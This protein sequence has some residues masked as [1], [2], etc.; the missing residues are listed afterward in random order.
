VAARYG[1][2]EFTV[3]LPQTT[4]QDATIIAER[5]CQEIEN[6]NFRPETSQ[7]S[8]TKLTVSVGLAS[9]PEDA[10]QLDDLIK[11]ADTALYA[12]KAQ[13]KNRVVVYE[14]QA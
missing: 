11:L 5:F 14:K 8:S 12:A 7:P 3:I 9:C 2:E 13:G 10:T 4:K 1:G 6:M